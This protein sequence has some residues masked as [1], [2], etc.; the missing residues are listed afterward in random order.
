MMMM[1]TATTW[2][3]TAERPSAP[4]RPTLRVLSQN[5]NGFGEG[6]VQAAAAYWRQQRADIVLLQETHVAPEQALGEVVHASWLQIPGWR[7]FWA[8][9]RKADASGRWRRG[10]AILFRRQSLAEGLEIVEGSISVP[11][12]HA[13]VEHRGRC[14]SLRVKWAGR[15]LHIASLYFPNLHSAQHALI[16]S[17]LVPLRNAA[18]D[19]HAS[20]LWGG[21][22]NFVL[23]PPLDRLSAHGPATPDHADCRVARHWRGSL[24]SLVDVFRARSPLARQFTHFTPDTA[25]RIDRFHV[26]SPLAEWVCGARLPPKCPHYAADH[27]PLTLDL[28]GRHAATSPRRRPPRLHLGF[29]VV[30]RWRDEFAA[31]LVQLVAEAP[32]AAASL[33]EWWEPAKRRILARA[34]MIQQQFRAELRQHSTATSAELHA[35]YRRAEAGDATALAAV[36]AAQ[37]ATAAAA[38][39][40]AATAAA[41]RRR[42]WLHTHERPSPLL[43]RALQPGPASRLMPALRTVSGRMVTQPSECARVLGRCIASVSKQ[44]ATTDAAQ[45]EVL[46]A[47]HSTAAPRITAPQAAALGATDIRED[48]VNKALSGSRRGTTP[49]L[50]CIPVE[51]YSRFREHLAPLLARL[52][53]AIGEQGHAPRNF[54][55]G[56]ITSIFKKGDRSNPANYRPIT[57]L[58]TDYRLL[59]K[60]LANRFSAV[61]PDVIDAEQTAF[62]SKRTIGDNIMAL[63]L[64][65]HALAEKGKWALAAFCDF[66]KAYD[67][68]DRAFLFKV[69]EAL[70]VGA[71]A[72]RWV[73]LLLHDTRAR[74]VANNC[75]SDAYRFEAGVRQGCPLSPLLY[76]FV[77]QA[78][79]RFLRAQG[80]GVVVETPAASPLSDRR[81]TALQYA[82]D[83]TALLTRG[84]VPL[85]MSSMAIFARASGQHLEP[86][87]THLLPLGSLPAS[88]PTHMAGLRLVDEVTNLGVCFRRG[89]AEPRVNWTECVRTVQESLRRL[90][91]LNLSPMGRGMGASGYALSRIFYQAEFAPLPPPARLVPLR[92]GVDR[93]VDKGSPAAS[94]PLGLRGDML[95]GSPKHGGFGVLPFELHVQARHAV[96]A[97]RFVSS[98]L[99]IPWVYLGRAIYAHRGMHIAGIF[100]GSALHRSTPA[101]LQRLEDGLRAIGRPHLPA[102][103]VPPEGAGKDVPLYGNPFLTSPDGQLGLD[104]GMPQLAVSEIRTLGDLVSARDQL[105]AL[106]PPN[107]TWKEGFPLFASHRAWQ[108]SRIHGLHPHIFGDLE[109]VLGLVNGMVARIP[110][111]WVERAEAELYHG[112]PPNPAPFTQYIDAWVAGAFWR[113]PRGDGT[114]RSVSISS[115]SV[116]DATAAL[117]QAP[118]RAARRRV[119]VDFVLDAA[120]GILPAHAPAAVASARAF[121]AAM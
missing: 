70:G 120:P 49:G 97:A 56:L 66:R 51:L 102:G 27:R 116:S 71:G 67:T 62:L 111:A 93:L 8:P 29:V 59:A 19:A 94:H 89:V 46:S 9:G 40:E 28:I 82:D 117:Q 114:L 69:M 60:V 41:S 1:P 76:L 96:W 64:F 75:M 101:P 48:E 38:A 88:L 4:R 84:Q 61:L 54:T 77:G 57:L 68:V 10:V 30:R 72:L 78:L 3:P 36:V 83:L 65:P 26:S 14:L 79:H 109:R 85:F 16:H 63:Q 107:A 44:P 119:F 100:L 32:A 45:T 37:A 113:L 18:H 7:G 17:C 115:L 11:Y 34:R 81:L 52:F 22:F 15:H 91:R 31:W 87:K 86:T 118:W 104:L 74:A 90:G 43:T 80:L 73:K 50:D 13:P 112:A 99:S 53:T 106:P 33:V 95:W 121:L 108:A 20:C 23:D 103:L 6:K 21:D 105:H 58:N 5:V 39:G 12:L 24:P 42:D 2:T 55:L 35:L 110:P 25:S 47:L 98:S 92:R